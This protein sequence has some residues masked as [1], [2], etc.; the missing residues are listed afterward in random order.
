MNLKKI[1]W[2]LTVF[3]ITSL[4]SVM[5]AVSADVNTMYLDNLTQVAVD[6][7]DV[8]YNSGDTLT[9]TATGS[10]AY[11]ITNDCPTAAPAGTDGTCLVTVNSAIETDNLSTLVEISDGTLTIPLFIANFRNEN[12]ASEAKRRVSPIL[13]KVVI[14]VATLIGGQPDDNDPIHYTYTDF[15]DEVANTSL[16]AGQY[17]ITY[18]AASYAL[19]RGNAVVWDCTGATSCAGWESDPSGLIET[20]GS[21]TTTVLTD[22]DATALGLEQYSFSGEDAKHYTAT[23]QVFTV[24]AGQTDLVVRF[25]VL[26]DEDGTDAKQT[27][28]H[29]II[30]G[31][32]LSLVADGVASAAYLGSISRKLS[33]TGPAL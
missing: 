26:Y 15:A 32:D 4:S 9:I 16:P 28:R 23:S 11:T 25:F 18:Y 2:G 12:T 5:A 6:D 24:A 17:R 20:S 31:G 10:T 21:T 19:L 14:E 1:I 27:N 3:S 8:H 30:L 29:S 7:V 33:L 13:E 22:I